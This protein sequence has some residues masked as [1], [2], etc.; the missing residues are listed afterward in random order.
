M[1]SALN[2]AFERLV[3]AFLSQHPELPHEWRRIE[4]RWW[5]SRVDL[6]CG[7]GTPN[8]VFATLH[9]HQIA[10]GPTKGRHE[11]FEDFG[12]GLSDEEVAREAFDRFVEVL[13]ESAYLSRTDG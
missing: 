1:T 12:R 7:V 5:G 9:G 3:R 13:A 2:E 8:E 4:S 11:D 6:I 10:V